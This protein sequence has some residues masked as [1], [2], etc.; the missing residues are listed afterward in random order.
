MVLFDDSETS[1]VL[2]E[3]TRV[4]HGLRVPMRDGVELSLDLVR[5]DLPGPLPVV[6]VRTPYDKVSSRDGELYVKLAQRGYITAFND[7][8]GRFNSDGVFRPQADE[9][10]DGY[11]TVEWIAAQEWC[12]GNVGMC[13]GSYGGQTQWYAAS[14]RPPHLKAI[15]PFCSPP[16]SLWRNEPIFGGCWLVGTA[17]WAVAMG[18]RS[19]QLLNPLTMLSEHQPYFDTLPLAAVPGAAGV[20]SPWWDEMM[21]H[22]VRDDFWKRREYEHPEDLAV[23]NITG[24]WDMNFPGAPLNFEAMRAGPSAAKQ[25]LVIGPWPHVVNTSRELNGVDFGEEAVIPLYDHVIRF[26]DRWLKGV[27]NGIEDEK[28][29]HVFVTGANQWWAEDDW[30]LP[31][32]EEV[33]YYF[34]AEGGLSPEQPGIEPPD[35]YR[36]DPAEPGLRAWSL[37]DGPVD[38]GPA[39]PRKDAV[40]YTSEPLTAPL[41]VVGWVTC[42]LWASSSALDTDW[43]V[44]LTDVHPDGSARFLCRGAL[45]ARFRHSFDEPELLEPGKPTLFE[46]TMDGTGVRFLPGHRIRVEVSSSAFNRYDRNTNSGADNPFTDDTIVVADQQIHHE[47][48]LASAVVLPVVRR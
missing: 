45:R 29:V 31:G 25:Q 47:A 22:P 11:D 30:P 36:Y 5:P 42:R 18:A 10:D 23:L 1:P 3:T 9:A 20:S 16:S 44:R 33:P 12:D 34:R 28:P 43:H 8:R 37:H 2:T 24:W 21:E 7:C 39:T 40:Y 17:E 38:D 35:S 13:G 27:G 48:G 4:V 46:F 14:R 26:F 32:T 6:L 19:W 41:D 15:V